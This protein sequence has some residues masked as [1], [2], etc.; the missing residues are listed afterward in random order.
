MNR[1][2][3]IKLLI[4]I[5]IIN[6]AGVFALG[7]WFY[8]Q[9]IQPIAV[10][11]NPEKIK[12]K[13][14]PIIEPKQKA[15]KEE[16]K[17]QP[18]VQKK[19]YQIT[20]NTKPKIEIPVLTYH[21]IDT[22]PQGFENDAIAVGL[23]VS[24]TAFELQ[25]KTLKEKGYKTLHIDEYEEITLGLKPIPPKSLLISIDDGFVDNYTQAFP[26]LKKYNLIG[27]FAII[28]GVLGT[29]EYMT[30]DQLKEM[31]NGGMGI[32]NHTTLHCSLSERNTQ[33]GVRVYLP[34]PVD[35]A[36]VPCPS[37]TFG[38]S[39][40]TGQ[41]E[42]ELLESKKFLDRELGIDVRTIVYPYGNYNQ[43][44]VDVLKKTGHNFGF[45]TKYSLDP[46]SQETQLFEL[47]RTA[48]GGQQTETLTGFFASI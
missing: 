34:N 17:P 36:V 43:Q 41:V 7:S 2:N 21:H 33:N 32:M 40:T 9:S 39:L 46:L 16:T 10:K 6:L 37:F 11:K 13:I 3:Y 26:I 47:P 25:M 5:S 48:I 20:S 29:R 24:P 45:T 35:N 27:N 23:R 4:V 1:K 30:L 22:I 31:H 18:K 28:T 8:S 44:T 38:G 15:T 12:P 14:S 19:S 42:Y